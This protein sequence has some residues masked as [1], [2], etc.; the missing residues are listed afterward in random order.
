MLNDDFFVEIALTEVFNVNVKN[1]LSSRYFYGTLK[2]IHISEVGYDVIIT[3]LNTNKFNIKILLGCLTLFAYGNHKDIEKEICRYISKHSEKILSEIDEVYPHIEKSFNILN[4]QFYES[5]LNKN[6]SYNLLKAL[7]HSHFPDITTK[8]YFGFQYLMLYIVNIEYNKFEYWYMTTKRR[9]LLL[10]FTNTL[11]HSFNIIKCGLN[12]NFSVSKI[13]WLKS[14]HALLIFPISRNFQVSNLQLSDVL[15]SKFEASEKIDIILFYIFNKYSS[16]D[17]QF[18]NMEELNDDITLLVELDI[19]KYFTFEHFKSLNIPY[20]RYYVVYFLLYSFENSEKTQILKYILK[21][22]DSNIK[23][24]SVT[25]H[26]LLFC[27]LYAKIL[28]ELKLDDLNLNNI[29]NI[30]EKSKKY[31][32]RPYIKYRE[33]H[34]W[35]KEIK[36]MFFYGLTLFIYFNK[37]PKQ[38]DEI[39]EDFKYF[40]KIGFPLYLETDLNSI[41]QNLESDL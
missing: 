4:V 38:C 8:I 5:I 20:D 2:N 37:L 30:Y 34:T 28:Q 16:Y 21:K 22:L 33:P 9:D 25:I 14:L 26:D 10:Y 13:G 32:F 3:Y 36:I 27:N 17:G 24:S 6:F 41:I 39:L 35:E 15:K 40:Q 7:N 11:L 31:L 23:K 12:K 29:K 19:S 18:K 1:I